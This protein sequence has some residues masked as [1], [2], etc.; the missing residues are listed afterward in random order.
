MAEQ[1]IAKLA[2]TLV[3]YSVSVKE[4]DLVGIIA[5]PPA[6]PLVQEVV[7]QVLRS[8]GYPYLLPY[9][10]PLPSFSKKPAMINLNT[11][12]ASGKPLTKILMF[13]FLLRANL[14]PKV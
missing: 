9:S 11:R 12:I 13:A 3:N 2:Q 14:I 1:R 5:Q 10:K 4:K 8:G 7:R 6:T